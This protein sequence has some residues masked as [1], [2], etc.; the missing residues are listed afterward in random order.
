MLQCG[1]LNVAFLSGYDF[2]IFSSLKKNIIYLKAY[3]RVIL[4]GKDGT[5]YISLLI[6]NY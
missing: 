4:T 2:F 5:S 3:G 6:K 1:M